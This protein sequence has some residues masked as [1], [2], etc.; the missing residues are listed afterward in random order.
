MLA[1]Q[2]Y[3]ITCNYIA[4][5]GAII[6]DTLFGVYLNEF[7][8]EISTENVSLLNKILQKGNRII[9]PNDLHEKVQNFIQTGY[10]GIEKCIARARKHFYWPGITAEIKDMVNIWNICLDESNQQPAEPI[11]PHEIPEIPRTKTGTDM[12]KLHKKL[13]LL[14]IIKLSF[15][16]FTLTVKQSSTVIIHLKIRFA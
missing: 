3:D 8:T 16:T 9:V 5:K 6:P 2:W 7:K 4:W 14:L 15:L 12:L 1:L 11:I 10:Q 13:W